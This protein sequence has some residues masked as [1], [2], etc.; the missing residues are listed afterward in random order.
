VIDRRLQLGRHLRVI[1][2]TDEDVRLEGDARLRPGQIV[3]LVTATAES[4]AVGRRA[5]V[6]SWT[7]ARLGSGGPIY[8]G[9]CRWQ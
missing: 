1:A 8:A 4:G 9:Q 3:E 2:E 5:C 7:V 6:I